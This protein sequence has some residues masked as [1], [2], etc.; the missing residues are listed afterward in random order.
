MNEDSR[1]DT[2]PNRRASLTPCGAFLAV[3]I[4]A[5]ALVYSFRLSSFLHAKEFAIALAL[6]LIAIA[7]LAE[8]RS[9]W[10]GARIFAPLW[11]LLAYTTVVHVGLGMAHVPAY[12]LE[13]A[14]RYAALLLLAGYGYSLLNDG[15][16]PRRALSTCIIVSAAAVA[17]LGL[18]QYAGLSG[19]LFPIFEDYTQRA[20][21]VFGNQDLFGGYVALGIPIAVA[22]FFN[23]TPRPRWMLAVMALLVAAL[24]ISGSRSAWLAALI[25][26][27]VALP[28]RRIS[29]R[30]A[31][32]FAGVVFA[33]TV[34]V[35]VLSPG[36]TL[37]RI[38]ASFSSADVGLQAR[39]WFW[40]A[41]LRMLRDAPVVGVGPGNFAYW[42]P[43]YQGEALHA[44]TGHAHY[45]N[46][47][48]TLHAHSDPL[49]LATETGLIGLALAAWMLWNMRKG[50][51]AEWGGLAAFFTFGLFNTT[52]H[53]APHLLIALLLTGALLSHLDSDSRNGAEDPPKRNRFALVAAIP[54]A[55]L[56]LGCTLL[57][58]IVPSHR[59]SA[60]RKAYDEG[61]GKTEALYAGTVG[62]LWPQYEAAEDWAIALLEAE[63][64]DELGPILDHARV[65]RDTWTIH[66]LSGQA[67]EHVGNHDDAI[68]E[69]RACL[70]RWPGFAPAW[71]ATLSLTQD[72]NER[73]ALLDEARSWLNDEKMATLEQEPG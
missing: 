43:S 32:W 55:I 36:P 31:L 29:L 35:S 67:L 72:P 46:S 44:P 12:T 14:A 9:P 66:Y 52:L 34:A 62:Y 58:T 27:L 49:E 45:H 4:V 5:G 64:F 39:L 61:S 8:N 60:A 6:A 51:G 41:S 59:L 2:P 73:Q 21:S 57:M 22:A 71:R 1:P 50:R 47:L 33:T 20:Y 25:G 30:T 24:L 54:V 19:P 37:N 23:E 28:Y 65:G 13:A 42:S 7:A 16:G 48:H 11:V 10:R 3:A 17:A 38:A 53:S 26:T 40:D 70:H 69:Y 18:L 68:E 15:P 56:L 63:R